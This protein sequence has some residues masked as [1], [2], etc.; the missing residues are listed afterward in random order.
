[1]STL[2]NVDPQTV[3]DALPVTLGLVYDVAVDGWHAGMIEEG[4]L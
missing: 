2:P 3:N 1:M 4:A